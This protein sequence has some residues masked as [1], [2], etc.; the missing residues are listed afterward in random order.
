MRRTFGW[1]RVTVTLGLALATA[2][3]WAQNAPDYMHTVYYAAQ[4]PTAF[5][6]GKC[7][8][9]VSTR[10][11]IFDVVGELSALGVNALTYHSIYG[12]AGALYPVDDPEL[13][14]SW[15]WP[16]DARPVDEF[17]DACEQFGVE[18]WPGVYL[19]AEGGPGLAEHA[20]DSILGTFGEHESVKGI[21]PPIEACYT[22]VDAENFIALS[23]RVK[24]TRPDLGIMDYPSAPYRPN[25]IQWIM[26]CALSGAV[27]VENVQFHACDDRIEDLR[28]A[29]GLTLM[30]IGCCPGIRCIIHTHYKNGVF[31]P[32]KPTEWLPPERAWDVTQSAIVTATPDG[33]S[34]FSFLHGFWGEQSSTPGGDS[35]WRRLK[36]YEGI[37]G[38]QRMLPIYA[39]ARSAARV[40]IMLPTGVLEGGQELVRRC[41]RPLSL[42]HIPAAFALTETNLPPETQIIIAPALPHCDREQAE[43]LQR[44]VSEGGTLITA[45]GPPPVLER[46]QK[47]LVDGTLPAFAR[48][49]LDLATRPDVQ[50]A[51]LDAGFATGASFAIA[52]GFEQAGALTQVTEPRRTSFGEG[53][54]IIAPAGEEWARANLAELVAGELPDRARVEGLPEGYMIERWRNGDADALM[55]LATRE[56]LAAEGVRITLPRTDLQRAWFLD[57][58]TAAALPL[59]R[60][61]DATT[62]AIPSL[63]DS[64]GIV[65]LGDAPWPVLRPSERLIRCEK[66]R[67]LQLSATL[68]NST[69]EELRG[70]LD[71]HAPEGWA[72]EPGASE[73]AMAPGE[74]HRFDFAATV[75][76]DVVRRPHFIR[77]ETAGLTQRIIIF[78]EDGTPQIITER[79]GPL[80]MPRPASAAP[81]TGVIGDEWLSVVAGEPGDQRASVHLPGV[82][83]YNME[84]IG[85]RDHEGKS[86]RYGQQMPGWGGPNFWVNNPDR[87]RDLQVRVT[88]LTAEPGRVQVYDGN[89][90]HDIGELVAGDEWR[91]DTWTVS[92]DILA[93]EDVNYGKR[94]PGFNVLLQFASPGVWVHSIEVRASD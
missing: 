73:F 18:A 84:W 45:G 37:V 55:I 29:R 67:A 94:L 85:A 90:Y 49:V 4:R 70:T 16:E 42:A 74:S 20:I 77:I 5:R 79:D 38:V 14:R 78:P 27:D 19:G 21:V 6:D 76:E 62:I 32:E 35:M 23:R 13:A 92:R 58:E 53:A 93:G 89:K 82:N 22:G 11:R 9:D 52:A 40:Q 3:A 46:Y 59:T 39:A 36:W 34:I 31:S 68:L 80:V 57:G 87:E 75:P 1:M 91:T 12:S 25:T 65:L 71:L 86:A 51:D 33:T 28:E 47:L 69:G 83:F 44:F 48:E 30:T 15:H 61:D 2:C 43:L 88:Y 63:G 26:R 54:V 10:E 7:V 8:C 50:P 81:A 64:F 56:G 60:E 72:V 24:Q 41:W 17:L 66:G